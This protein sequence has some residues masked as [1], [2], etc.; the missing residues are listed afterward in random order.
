MDFMDSMTSKDANSDLAAAYADFSEGAYK[1][2][3]SSF[4]DI[5]SPEA[6]YCLAFHYLNGRGTSRDAEKGFSLL[7]SA[8]EHGYLPAVAEVG[9]CYGYGIG[10]DTDD[11]KAFELFTRAAEVGDPYGMAMLSMMYLNGDGVKKDSRKAEEWSQRCEDAGDLERI[12][13]EGMDHLMKGNVILARLYL[14]RSAVM[15]SPI[16]A[17][18][19][20]CLYGH[21]EGVCRD[22][23]EASDWED[24]ADCNG[25]DEVTRTDLLDY[26]DWFSKYIEW[27][28][29]EE[30]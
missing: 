16:S 26:E 17:K 11:A 20:A 27:Y 25:W 19:L 6:E 28:E 14:M 23:D 24:T 18:V 2:S 21:G 13:A 7:V 29:M 9:Q 4:S 15:G 8:M 10:T 22:S 30:D 5:D 3:F 1:A 12:E